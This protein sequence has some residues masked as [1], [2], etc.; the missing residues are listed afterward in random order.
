MTD[1]VETSDFLFV[2]T[3][4]GL[5]TFRRP[6]DDAQE[7]V[8][9]LPGRA[10]TTVSAQGDTLLAGATDGLLLSEDL[11]WRRV[12]PQVDDALAVAVM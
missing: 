7:V 10:M 12:L 4:N 5:R 2:A 3:K 9:T 11:A 8:H 6:L 1:Q